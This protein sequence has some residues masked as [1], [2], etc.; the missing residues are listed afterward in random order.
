MKYIPLGL[1]DY[2]PNDIKKRDQLIQTMK[3]VV[4]GNGYE[5]II[6]PS[7]E[8]FDQIQSALGELSEDCIMFFD[9][10]GT[11][12]VLRPDHTTPIARIV[13]TRLQK[14]CPIKLYYHDPVFRKDPLLGE[15]EIFQFGC[16]QIGAISIDDEVKMIEMA[17]DVCKAVGLDDI[18]IHVS[19]PELFKSFT[20]HDRKALDKGNLVSFP[21]LPRKGGVS[22]LDDFPYLHQLFNRIEA[23]NLTNVFVNFGLFKDLSYYNGLF[24]DIVSKSY[25]KVIGSGGRYDSVLRAFNFESNAIGFALRLHYIDRA[26]NG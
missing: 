24:F 4:E 23:L 6:T 26:L 19:H 2:L 7:I 21:T 15:T 11:R 12:L 20:E 16:E 9:G 8:S 10:S 5:R 25:G 14:Q 13:S 17:L 1:R 22:L 18:E 3:S